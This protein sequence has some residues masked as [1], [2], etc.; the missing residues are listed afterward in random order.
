MTLAS[1]LNRSNSAPKIELSF[2]VIYETENLSS[3]ELDNVYRSLDSISRQT[4]KP[5][6]ANEFIII[7]GGYVSQD[8]IG[9]LQKKYPWISIH[10][11]KGVQYYDGKML[12]ASLVSGDIVFFLDSDC[13]YVSD[14]FE[15]TL[16]FLQENPDVQIVAGESSTPIRNVYE[17]AIAC[18]FF[19]PR[20]SK[21]QQPYE[22]NYYFLNNVAFRRQFL[23]E[24]P[25]PINQPTYRG[26]CNL[27]AYYLCELG[28]QKIIKL[29]LSQALHEPPQG[30]FI[31]W[32]Y[33]L[34]GRDEVL[35]SHL[36]LYM[37][38]E[39]DKTLKSLCE[40][41]LS[42]E[43]IFRVTNVNRLNGIFKSFLE[44]KPF[45]WKKIKPVLRENR[46]LVASFLLAAVYI[47]MFEI[48]Y[49]IGKIITF[50]WPDFLFDYYKKHSL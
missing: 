10:Y 41:G 39:R 3:V 7:D 29:P 13:E 20:Y 46:K 40:E 38:K 22:S 28:Q 25:I 12:G 23:L 19:F 32:R 43:E 11:A 15:Q 48:L 16:E 42:S 8:V 14:L 36:K 45:K 47:L 18:H 17:L 27:H 34:M 35:K 4:I 37:A 33:L 5:Q 31:F 9:E 1:T 50:I 44:F 26:N 21:H 2:S 24:N 49:G 6:N 30:S